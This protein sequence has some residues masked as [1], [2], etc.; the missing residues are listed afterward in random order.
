MLK[1]DEQRKRETSKWGSSEYLGNP[2]PVVFSEPEGCVQEALKRGYRLGFTAGSD[3]HISRPGSNIKEMMGNQI[4]YTQSGLTAVYAE[5]LSREAI[6]D[7]LKRRHCYATTG[8]R[9]IIYFTI[10]DC[11]MGEEIT[12]QSPDAPRQLYIKVAG[13]KEIERIDIVRNNKNIFSKESNKLI[14]EVSYVDSDNLRD[15]ALPVE[16]RANLVTF[17]YIRVIQKDGNW[18]WSSPVWVSTHLA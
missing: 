8:V 7:A 11:L 5:E 6:F 16:L 9:M 18:G 15:I 12:V 14:E 10:N 1:C 3:T 2:W 4:V 13:T 17:Y